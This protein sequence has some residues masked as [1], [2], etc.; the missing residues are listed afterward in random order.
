MGGHVIA[1]FWGTGAILLQLQ[2]SFEYR[3]ECF[4][5][6]FVEVIVGDYFFMY[7]GSFYCVKVGKFLL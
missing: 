3:V 2:D 5:V 4:C 1:G 7:V 6:V